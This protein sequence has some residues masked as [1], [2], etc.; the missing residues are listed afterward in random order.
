LLKSAAN[1]L[2]EV[3]N[4]EKDVWQGTTPIP[5]FITYIYYFATLFFPL[6]YRRKQGQIKNDSPTHLVDV[7]ADMI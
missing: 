6:F 1:P 7:S 2:K 3:N 4:Q 5:M